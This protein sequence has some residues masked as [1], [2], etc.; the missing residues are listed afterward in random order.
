MSEIEKR[1]PNLPVG[2]GQVD[3]SALAGGGGNQYVG[4][5]HPAGGDFDLVRQAIPDVPTGTPYYRD[6][7]TVHDLRNIPV[8]VAQGV[9]CYVVTDGV[10]S[11]VSYHATPD[12]GRKQH[13]ICAF[14]IHLPEGSRVVVG[15]LRGPKAQ[16][17]TEVARAAKATESPDW[18]DSKYHKG[19]RGSLPPMLRVEGRFRMQAGT[20][21]SG[22]AYHVA[23]ADPVIIRP[24]TLDA[25]GAVPAEDWEAG[26]ARF[27]EMGAQIGE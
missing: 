7:D 9:T 5:A 10:G 20:S 14:V 4:F 11:P 21:K 12:A 15:E 16:F 17:L 3:E 6:G 23:H 25:L 26:A 2:F 8:Q 18:G 22:Y 19:V 24:E 13:A 27:T 1:V